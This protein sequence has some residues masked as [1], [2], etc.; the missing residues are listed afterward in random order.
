MKGLLVIAFMVLLFGILHGQSI[1]LAEDWEEGSEGWVILSTTTP[2]EWVR[3]TAASYGEGSHSMYVSQDGGL[4]NTYYYANSNNQSPNTT[5]HFYKD[6]EIPADQIDINLSFDIRCVGENN[7]DFVRVYLMP[8]TITPV[9]SNTSITATANDPHGAYRIGE[10]RYNLNTLTEPVGEWHSV[11]IALS[12]SHS[13]SER[14]LV[15]TWI[16]DVSNQGLPPGAIDNIVL[17]SQTATIPPLVATMISP[18]DNAILTP[19]TPNLIWEFNPAGASPTGCT[20]YIGT[21]NPPTTSY[22][23]GVVTSWLP[24][25][26]LENE[27]TYYWQVV[28]TNGSGEAEGCPVWSFTTI[29]STLIAVGSG[30]TL[31]KT[32]PI[33]MHYG[34]SLTQSIYLEQELANMPSGCEVTELIYHYVGNTIGLN[35]TV[36][37]YMGHTTLSEFVSASA[38]IPFSTLT[39]VYTGSLTAEQGDSYA[40]VTFN[41]EPFVYQGGNIVVAFHENVQGYESAHGYSN[42][43]HS[44]YPGDYRSLYYQNDYTAASIDSPPSGSRTTTIANTLFRYGLPE[45]SYLT[46]TP[47]TV[48]LGTL[49]AGDTYTSDVTLRNAGNTPIS[50]SNIVATY[51]IATTYAT[52]FVLEAQESVQVP[53]SFTITD[54]IESFVGAITFTS[55]ASNGPEHMVNVTARVIPSNMSEIL[56]NGETEQMIPVNNFYRYT[57]SQSIYLPSEINQPSGSVIEELRYHFNAN[58]NFTQ[59]VSI[60]MGYTAQSAFA[61]LTYI[62]FSELRQVY[63]G[64]FVMSSEVDPSTGG[65]W[66]NITL[67]DPFIYDGNSHLVIAVL[68]SES[69]T[70]GSS[71]DRFYVKPTPDAHRSLCTYNDYTPIYPESITTATYQLASV[72]ELVLLFGSAIEGAY[73]TATPNSLNY[74]VVRAG[75]GATLPV[76]IANIGSDVLTVSSITHP[77]NIAS[78]MTTLFAIM[79]GESQV[80]DFTLTLNE[81]GAFSGE[82]VIESN[83]TNSETVIIPV[84]AMLLP[85]QLV[86]VGDGNLQNMALPFEPFY[87]YTYS[88]TIYTPDDLAELEDGNDIIFI[89]YQYNGNEIMQ[90]SAKIYMGYTD[91]ASFSASQSSFIDAGGLTLV[92]DGAIVTENVP[93]S[94]VML[95]LQESFTYDASRNLVVA[96]NEYYGGNYGSTTS[97]Y[98]CTTT[99]AAQS[100]TTYNDNAP[101]DELDFMTTNTIH[102]HSCIPNTVFGVSPGGLPRPRNLQAMADYGSV[103]LWWEAPAVTP[104]VT[105]LGYTVYRSGVDIIAGL[106]YGQAQYADTEGIPGVEYS[107]W[108][109]AEY[110]INGVVVASAPSNVVIIASFVSDVD[111]VITPAVTKLSGNYPN[112]F[113]PTTTISF[114]LARED[115]VN[116]EVYNAKGQRV[117][118]LACEV[119]GAGRHNVVWDGLADNGVAVGSGVY[120]Y[121]MSVG[122][123]ACVRKMVMVK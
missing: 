97:D 86:Y 79:A 2:N 110:L 55:N 119:R 26:P 8:T 23:V 76:T 67:D 22:A 106:A 47:F 20:V 118:V 74:G 33:N 41:L 65:S 53:F 40:S 95:P 99:T 77:S 113:N 68:D 117:K 80:I 63:S 81:V 4:T 85:E 70:F 114:E 43:Y 6:V 13:G 42:W 52:S 109:V 93:Q 96:F 56:G 54:N 50:I 100:I 36:D 105:F 59:T 121:R 115:Y 66:V 107:Y 112:P 98:Y 104:E 102:A 24:T 35:E 18:A 34:Y 5:I 91:Q 48:N 11:N 39:H 19:I 108:V 12:N 111:E 7:Y 73:I 101:Y 28:P 31:S 25:S 17:T 89:G 3:G 46:V 116:I 32:L 45:G 103:T 9:A 10:D 120:F 27:T 82:I 1:I 38:W 84:T 90:Q 51:G 30:N 72:P 61:E 78:N 58:Q 44:N 71:S 62:P 14:R 49:Y 122:E 60:Y 87:R 88:Q 83:A 16:N 92:Y 21:E 94:W 15:F 123:Y 64:S 37:I 69:G 29:E 75:E 57:Y